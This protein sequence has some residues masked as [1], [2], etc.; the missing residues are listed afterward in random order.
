MVAILKQKFS[1]HPNPENPGHFV[2]ALFSTLVQTC[3]ELRGT[4]GGA[5]SLIV[6]APKGG[7][8][9]HQFFFGP[10]VRK[11]SSQA[12]QQRSFLQGLGLHKDVYS[13]YHCAGFKFL[14]ALSRASARL[15][16]HPLR[17]APAPRT[18]HHTKMVGLATLTA[19]PRT[20]TH[21]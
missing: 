2:E 20:I 9:F 4:L 7:Q 13:P 3:I 17:P 15:R 1:S 10:V 12:S 6:K 19:P 18:A 8:H 21:N 5:L 14:V 11:Y 16:L